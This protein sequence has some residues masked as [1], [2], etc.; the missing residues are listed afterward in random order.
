MI[1]F[2]LIIPTTHSFHLHKTKSKFIN[3]FSDLKWI[4][5][6]LFCE[7]VN[8]SKP[9]N[10]YFIVKY[11]ML[12][13]RISTIL[14]YQCKTIQKFLKLSDFLFLQMLNFLKPLT[15]NDFCIRVPFSIIDFQIFQTRCDH[16]YIF[17]AYNPCIKIVTIGNLC[18]LTVCFFC[19]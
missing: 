9:D 10:F 1:K 11:Q 3:V 14:S 6:V 17:R 19:F 18:I 7:V 15:S 5:T 16:T 12:I 4:N 13:L 8:Q 2:S